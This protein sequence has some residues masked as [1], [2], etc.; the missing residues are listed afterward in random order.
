MK[1][2]AYKNT[3]YTCVNKC[4]TETVVLP[5]VHLSKHGGSHHDLHWR[6]RNTGSWH[7]SRR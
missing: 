3:C 1:F 5:T 4:Y 6:A 7:G 2:A